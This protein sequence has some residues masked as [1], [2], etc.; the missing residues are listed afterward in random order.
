M[1]LA[2]AAMALSAAARRAGSRIACA[3]SCT[4][5]L[6]SAA[7]TEEPGASEFF[8]GSAVAYANSAKTSILGVGEDL[9][10]R[11]GAVSA[12]TADAMARGALAAFGADHAFSITGVAGPDGGTE[13]KPVGTVWFGFASRL[14][15]GTEKKSFM[16]TR[17]AVRTSAAEFALSRLSELID[18]EAKNLG[19]E[20]RSERVRA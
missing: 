8:V 17:S 12:E 4:G 20:G 16:G 13:E 2:D 3:E 14:G 6:A 7:I 1:S 15:S 9:I 10:E 18:G 19:T 5:G 11:C